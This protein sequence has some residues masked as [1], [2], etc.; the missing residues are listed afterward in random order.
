MHWWRDIASASYAKLRNPKWL[1]NTKNDKYGA[2]N[3]YLLYCKMYIEII[4]ITT[5]KNLFS[6]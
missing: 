6:A 2:T 5:N 4:K 3:E 1:V